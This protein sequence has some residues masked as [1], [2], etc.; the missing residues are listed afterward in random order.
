MTGMR[1]GGKTTMSKFFLI[2][3]GAIEPKKTRKC[4]DNQSLDNQAHHNLKVVL[5]KP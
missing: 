4:S 5:K 1:S 3:G 2:I